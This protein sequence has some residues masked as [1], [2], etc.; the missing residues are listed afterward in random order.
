MKSK[1]N[2][3]EGQNSILIT[4]DIDGLTNLRRIKKEY[5]SSLRSLLRRKWIFDSS[6]D[7]G[8]GCYA[9][10]IVGGDVLRE[11]L[12]RELRCHTEEMK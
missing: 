11:L 9:L 4:C 8:K 5:K 1:Y 3:T 10:T 6:K 7:H 2:L 12:G